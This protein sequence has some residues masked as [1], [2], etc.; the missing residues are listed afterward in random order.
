MIDS[1]VAKII[2]NTTFMNFIFVQI[3]LQT[4]VDVS[5]FS[6]MIISLL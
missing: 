1:T 2:R 4:F 6:L 5:Q 3:F